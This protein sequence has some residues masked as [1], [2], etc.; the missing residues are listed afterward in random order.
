[1]DRNCLIPEGMFGTVADKEKEDHQDFWIVEGVDDWQGKHLN[2]VA[3]LVYPSAIS[4]TT[5]TAVELHSQSDVLD[6]AMLPVGLQL[7]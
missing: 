5:N 7:T 6:K 3:W 1:M 2:T 4:F